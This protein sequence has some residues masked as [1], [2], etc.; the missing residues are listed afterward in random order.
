MLQPTPATVVHEVLV[1]STKLKS[2]AAS[3]VAWKGFRRSRGGKQKRGIETRHL[4][5]DR[6]SLTGV[7]RELDIPEERVVRCKGQRGAEEERGELPHGG[8]RSR[9]DNTNRACAVGFI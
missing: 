1:V 2:L 4:G 8:R 7:S 5:V 3:P 6:V 9:T